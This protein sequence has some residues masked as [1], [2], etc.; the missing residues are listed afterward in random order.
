MYIPLPELELR[1]QRRYQKLVNEH[2]HTSEGNAAGSR[3]LPGLTEAFAST[4]AAWR[5]YNNEDVTLPGLIVPL[6]EQARHDLPTLCRRYGLVLHDW[7]NLLF[8]AHT[9]KPDRRL[10]GKELGYELATALLISDQTGQPIVPVSLGLWAADGWHTTHAQQVRT[11][12]SALDVTTETIGALRQLDW[13]LPLVQIIDR[14]GDSVFHY[15]QW[16]AAGD[17]FLVRANDGQ[18]VVWQGRTHLLREVAGQ[19]E[20]H[21]SQ[22]VE[23]AAHVSGQLLV[24]ATEVV[25]ERPAFPRARQGKRRWRT[26]EPLSLRLIVCQIRLP[27][28]TLAAEWYLLS[29]VPDEVSAGQLAEWYYWRW[30]IESYFKLLKSHGF[31]IESWQQERAEKIAKRLLVAAM[32]CVVV[33]HLQRATEPAAVA[34]SELQIRLSGRQVRRGQATAPA[35]LAGLWVFL[36]ALELLEHYDLDDLK[37]MARLAVPGYS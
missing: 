19:V 12:L 23:V 16:D 22:A 10:I 7:S 11:E 14:E 8:G 13:G 28:E 33:W 4:Q 17:L 20:L 24:G 9:S 25:L 26:G 21:A 2:L 15:R 35:L 37:S 30:R 5:F 3:A 29:N 18:R 6:Q 34:L 36:A 32:A 31:Q 1:L 27:D